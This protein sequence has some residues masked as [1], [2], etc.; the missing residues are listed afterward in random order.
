[1]TR[2]ITSYIKKLTVPSG[3]VYVKINVGG[4]LDP[5]WRLVVSIENG[6]ITILER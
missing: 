4:V 1:M 3:R 2:D 6:I 5:G